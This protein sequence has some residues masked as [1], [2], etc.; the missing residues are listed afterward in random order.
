LSGRQ[1]YRQDE[2]KTA[3]RPDPLARHFAPI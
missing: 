1:R 3:K 2:K